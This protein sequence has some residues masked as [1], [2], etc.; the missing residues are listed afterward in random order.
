MTTNTTTAATIH[1]ARQNTFDSVKFFT[2]CGKSPGFARITAIRTAIANTS[3]GNFSI[4]ATIIDLG[5]FKAAIFYPNPL[6]MTSCLI[7]G[8]TANQMPFPSGSQIAR[9]DLFRFCHT[10]CDLIYGIER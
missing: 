6:V 5:R 7:S 1:P 2:I 4:M 3:L 10:L 8:I 9:L